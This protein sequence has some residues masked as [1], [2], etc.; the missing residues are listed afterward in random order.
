[1][2][3]KTMK[4]Y[5]KKS[6]P[7]LL[8]MAESHFNKFVRLRDSKDGFGNCISSG[9]LLK[10]P[11][12]EAHCGHYYPAGPYPRLRFNEDN[13]HLQSRADNYFKSGNLHEYRKNLIRKIGLERVEALDLLAAI[14]T[15]HKWERFALIE[16]C[17]T[18]KQKIKD[19]TPSLIKQLKK[20][21]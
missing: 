13:C 7:Q 3:S 17:E 20:A 4:K 1:M 12:M 19:L 8:K 10:V 6:V 9:R 14:K 16:T 2:D 15:P 5:D 11:S 21:S 18:Y